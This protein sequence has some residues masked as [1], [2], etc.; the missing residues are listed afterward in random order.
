[1][2]W[3]SAA[4]RPAHRSPSARHEGRAVAR[5]PCWPNGGD[6]LAVKKAAEKG[7][8]VRPP[9]SVA[10]ADEYLADN[11]DGWSNLKTRGTW[12]MTLRDG[13]LPQDRRLPIGSIGV[14]EVL[15][16]LRPVLAREAGGPRAGFGQ[17]A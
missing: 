15:S 13:L 7:G 12:A 9:P 11:R 1:M 5:D 4:Q 6:P 3:A 16:V 8:W 2:G 17:C 14:D 10:F